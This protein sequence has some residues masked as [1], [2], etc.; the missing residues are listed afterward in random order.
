MSVGD[1]QLNQKPRLSRADFEVASACKGNR[2]QMLSNATCGP[3]NAI[4]RTSYYK[5]FR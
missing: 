2:F 3:P 4:E 5:I 1:A